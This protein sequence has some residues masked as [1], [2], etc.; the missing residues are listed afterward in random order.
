MAFNTQRKTA[1]IRT[2]IE[3]VNN[4]GR[5]ATMRLYGSIGQ[6]VDGDLFAPGAG[7]TR[8]GPTGHNQNTN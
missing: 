6:K 7:R 5:E 3:T 4:E 8:D 1:A 2:N